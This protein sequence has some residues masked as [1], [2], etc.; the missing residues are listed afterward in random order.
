MTGSEQINLAC[1]VK[2]VVGFVLGKVNV[3]V[4]LQMQ[5]FV[6]LPQASTLFTYSNVQSSKGCLVI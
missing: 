3:V 4:S 6:M 5:A 1:Q 2:P